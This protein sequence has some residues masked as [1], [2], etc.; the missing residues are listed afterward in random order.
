MATKTQVQDSAGRTAWVDNNGYVWTQDGKNPTYYKLD[1]WNERQ[2]GRWGSTEDQSDKLVDEISNAVIELEDQLNNIPGVSL[3]QEEMDTF[4]QKA[5]DQVTPYY[6]TKKAEI[7]TGIKEGK[8]QVAEDVLTDIRRIRDEVRTNLQSLD[9]NQAETEEDFINTLADI[10]ASKEEDVASKRFEWGERIKVAKQGQV[11]SGILTSGIGRKEVGNLESRQQAEQQAVERSAG[12]KET[13]LQ[14]G[15]KFDLER[16]ALARQAVAQQRER[17]L[18]TASQE[19]STTTG[20]LGT[21][22]M[23]DI[24][25]LPSET[26]LAR[27]R[28]ERNVQVYRP[29]ALTDLGEEKSR[30]I[31]SR[32]LTLQGEELAAKQQ[33]E[34]AQR[35]KIYSDISKKKT[36]LSTYFR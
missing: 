29:S 19:A 24:N 10:T 27:Q 13:S 35:N 36:Q 3:S 17:Q 14:T 16:I 12:V 11:E 6:D 26:E 15:Q 2:Q 32:K 1:E 18:G 7:E 20:A 22:G 28:A 21:L 33:Q 30:S 23:T 31:E 25:Q 34:Q 4:L 9:I 5:I 8:T